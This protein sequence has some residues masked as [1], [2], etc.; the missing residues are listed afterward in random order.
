MRMK[1]IPL[2]SYPFLGI[3]GSDKMEKD[4]FLKPLENATELGK[5]LVEAV[6]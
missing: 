2:K 5:L 3:G 1:P 4:D 6:T